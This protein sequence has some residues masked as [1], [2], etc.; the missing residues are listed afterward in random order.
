[1]TSVIPF[2]MPV[3]IY[4][5]AAGPTVASAPWV[6]SLTDTVLAGASACVLYND[7]GSD[8]A[9]L[10]VR[11]TNG[12]LFAAP[13]SAVNTFIISGGQV[14]VYIALAAPVTPSAGASVYRNGVASAATTLT[15]DNVVW[16]TILLTSPSAS[17]PANPTATVGLV[18]INGSAATFMRS[19]AAPAINLAITP[20]WTG[21]HT[22]NAGLNSA[23]QIA[24]T[25]AGAGVTIKGGTNAKIGTATLVGGAATVANTSVTANSLIFLTVQNGTASTG[26]VSVGTKT[27]G[28]SFTIVSSNASDT[29]TVA[30]LIVEQG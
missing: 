22:F 3:S 28:T 11:G 26:T 2:Q 24:T 8:Y 20:T 7:F 15:T 23:A 12:W 29:T 21:L 14:A 1:M 10:Y 9:G 5:G 30:Y 17:T 19:D 13:Y 6:Q 16:A 18:A 25:T 27:A 4:Q